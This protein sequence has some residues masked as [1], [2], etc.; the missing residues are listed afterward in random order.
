MYVVVFKTDQINRKIGHHAVLIDVAGSS[1]S[2]TFDDILLHMTANTI[3]QVVKFRLEDK[4]WPKD[5]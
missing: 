2:M 4:P 1:N 5:C 3:S